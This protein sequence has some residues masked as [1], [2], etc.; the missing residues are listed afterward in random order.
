VPHNYRQLGLQLLIGAAVYGA[1]LLWAHFTNK[2]LR[3]GELVASR[4]LKPDDV[5]VIVGAV[6]TYRGDI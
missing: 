6:E 1:A 3:T 4:D 5:S 2:A